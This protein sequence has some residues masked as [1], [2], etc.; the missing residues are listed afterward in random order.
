MTVWSDVGCPWASLALHVLHGEAIRLGADLIIDHRAFPLE[1]FNARPTPKPTIDM[2]VT[3]IAALVPDLSW[4]PWS[5]PDSHY[6]VTTLPALA[7][8]QAAKHPDVGG[9]VASDRLDTALRTAWYADSRCI[10][11]PSVIEDIARDCPEV[12]HVELARRLHS[13]AGISEVH[14]QFAAAQGPSVQGSPQIVADGVNMH[15]PGVTYHWTAPP[16]QGFPRFDSYR[17]E[18]ATDLLLAGLRLAR[19]PSG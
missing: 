2:E 11:V 19:G 8:V 13:G 6:P 4:R 7:A 17:R 5:A 18:W 15:N 16:P 9:L 14:E 10:S 1:L 12:D 3:A